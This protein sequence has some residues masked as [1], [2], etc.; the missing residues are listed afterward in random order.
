MKI[1][2]R[3]SHYLGMACLISAVVVLPAHPPT[4]HY[5]WRKL[6]AGWRSA[7]VAA[8]L[9]SFR[10][11]Y[12]LWNLVLTCL[13][14]GKDLR[15]SLPGSWSVTYWCGTCFLMYVRLWLWS[16]TCRSGNNNRRANTLFKYPQPLKGKHTSYL[17]F[18]RGNPQH[19][20]K[21]QYDQSLK[22]AK[23]FIKVSDTPL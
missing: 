22:R 7:C 2:Y 15:V 14:M 13:N 6:E 23:L 12:L 10:M 11:H 4:F 18:N 20:R 9:H 1:S 16:T 19:W 17:Y 21:S 3:C 8:A 5:L